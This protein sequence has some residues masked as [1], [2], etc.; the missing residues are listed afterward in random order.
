MY[1]GVACAFVI[2]SRDAALAPAVEALGYRAVI[3]DTVMTDGGQ[4]LAAAIH[5]ASPRSGS[6]RIA[7]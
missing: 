1:A 6:P 5:A 3:T 4:R 2:D 7:R